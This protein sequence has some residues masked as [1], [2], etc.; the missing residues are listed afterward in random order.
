ME[1]E[2]GEDM[3]RVSEGE[4]RIFMVARPPARGDKSWRMLEILKHCMLTRKSATKATPKAG[5][6][7][8]REKQSEGLKGSES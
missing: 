8:S 1:M 6:L 2:L 4:G 7:P 5:W 3:H